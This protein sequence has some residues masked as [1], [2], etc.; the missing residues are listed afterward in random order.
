MK[1]SD[2]KRLIVAV[3]L[4]LASA[5][6]LAFDHGH[7]A[8]D[9]LLRKYVVLAPGG[10]ASTVRYAGLQAERKALRG[11][12]DALSG[13]SEAEYGHWTRAQKLAFLINAYNA[14]TVELVL[15][16]YPD[17]KSIKDLG[18]VF[19]SP[20]KRKFFTL[21]GRERTLDDIEHNLIRA[22]GAF[23]EPRIHVAVVCASVG[24]PM[25]RKEAFTADRLD[26]QL[27]DSTRR[28][29]ADRNRNRF[30]AATDTL[31]VS[32]IFDW[33]GVDFAKEHAGFTSLKATF[34]RYADRFAEV[35]RNQARIRAGDYR[36]DFLDYDWTL[37][38]VR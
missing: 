17:L 23:D 14:F 36:I 21:L 4:T 37:N 3:A 35:P 8:W 12:L 34:A 28:F 33:Y 19:Q 1:G 6:A 15:G 11:Y 13:V 10:N 31:W 16:K 27:E 26:T 2:V 29:F 5:A 9:A 30:D 22:P 38:D 7:A 24:C 20:W 25:L 32:K 18:N